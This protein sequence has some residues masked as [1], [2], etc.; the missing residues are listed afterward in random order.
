MNLRGFRHLK[1]R[2][3]IKCMKRYVSKAIALV[4]FIFCILSFQ[5][6]GPGF[7]NSPSNVPNEVYSVPACAPRSTYEAMAAQWGFFLISNEDHV[8]ENLCGLRWSRITSLGWPEI[9][10]K[11]D[12]YKWPI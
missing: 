5:N 7:S 10:P 4:A 8:A 1:K 12:E 11:P 3:I 6:C 9:E 2:P